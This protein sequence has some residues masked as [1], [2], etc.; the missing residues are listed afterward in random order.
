MH[1]TEIG[2]MKA[3]ANSGNLPGEQSGQLWESLLDQVQIDFYTARLHR[4]AP[5]WRVVPRVIRDEMLHIVHAGTVGW[6]IGEEKFDSPPGTVVFCPPDVEWES[7][8]VSVELIE[9]TIIHF[10][11][12]FP[13]R[14]RYLKALGYAS[15]VEPA[16]FKRISSLGRALNRS[17]S[18]QEAGHALKERAL[19]YDLFH[20]LFGVRGQAETM[21]EQG[22]QALQIV[23][24]LRDNFSDEI[25]R[26]TLARRFH[27]S[28]GHLAVIFKEYT[29]ESP[30]GYLLRL[31]MQRASELLAVTS[32]PVAEIAQAVGHGD[33][34]YFSRI[35]K[36]QAGVSPL[37]YRKEQQQHS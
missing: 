9:M 3:M 28:S 17:F 2:R 24:F 18:A 20:E 27:L 7:D 8:R 37:Q 16:N 21:S 22:R 26:D 36:Q 14:Q 15:C 19:M 6:R 30:M 25:T 4:C 31:R 23:E 11:A 35:F 34:A 29:G 5:D 33:A 10:D 13:G 32:L 12:Y 1:Q